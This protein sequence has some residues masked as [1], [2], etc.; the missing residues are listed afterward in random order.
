MRLGIIDTPLRLYD[1]SEGGC[2]VTALHSQPSSIEFELRIELPYEGPITVMGCPRYERPQFG[3]GVQFTQVDD[4]AA[5][6][7][8][9]S[10]RRLET[11]RKLTSA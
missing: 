2:F 5:D 10:L 1:L 3:Y 4:I 6:K 7:L 11:A 9:R 8:H